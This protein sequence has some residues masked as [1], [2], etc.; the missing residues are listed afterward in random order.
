MK[1]S[2]KKN[3]I[4]RNIFII[5]AVLLFLSVAGGIAYAWF[6][7]GTDYIPLDTYRGSIRVAYFNG[8]GGTAPADGTTKDNYKETGTTYPSYANDLN[9]NSRT[10]PYQ[11]DN[12]TQ[13][14]NFAWLQYLGFFNKEGAD[15]TYFVL[16]NDIDMS[17]I[18]LPPIGNDTNP[19]IG[20]FDGNGNYLSASGTNAVTNVTSKSSATHWYFSNS[21]NSGYISTIIGTTTY[22]LRYNN[23]SLALTTNTNNRTSWSN[24][25]GG[26][27]Y[28]YYNYYIRFNGTTWITSTTNTDTPIS[29]IRLKDSEGHYV[30]GSTSGG[31]ATVGN[32]VKGS[33]WKKYNNYY[34]IVNDNGERSNYRLVYY[35]YS[36][37]YSEPVYVSTSTSSYYYPYQMDSDGRLYA[38]ISGT[39]YYVYYSNGSWA[40]TTTDVNAA[41]FTEETVNVTATS[42]L[43]I[44]QG[45]GAKLYYHSAVPVTAF[46]SINVSGITGTPVDLTNIGLTETTSRRFTVESSTEPVGETFFPLAMMKDDNG[47]YQVREEN[48][49]YIIIGGNDT[50]KGGDIR[51]SQYSKSDISNSVTSEAASGQLD[52]TKIYT[53]INS[54]NTN[55]SHAMTAAERAALHKFEDSFEKL[56]KTLE[57]T[58]DVYGLHFM[59][60]AISVSDYV[61]APYATIEGETYTNYE[62]PRNCIDFNLSEQG[63]IN[64]FAGSYFSGNNSFFSLHKIIRYKEGDSIPE[65]KKVNDLKEIR[66]I[67][68]VYQNSNDSDAPYAYKFSDGIYAYYTI[69]Q[70]DELIEHITSSLSGYTKIFDTSF[71]EQPN[72]LLSSN[73]VTKRVYYFEIPANKGEYALGSVSTKSGAYL[74]YLDIG[75]G[76]TENVP[77][78]DALLYADIRNEADFPAN[79]ESTT[80]SYQET[81]TETKSVNVNTYPTY[82]PLAF[83][84]Q[85]NGMSNVNTGYLVS[86]ATFTQGSPLGDIRVSQ[87]NKATGTYNI[88]ESLTNGVLTDSKIYTINGS[89][90]QTVSVYG[91]SNF[92]KY[93]RSKS[94]MQGVLDN[95]NYV[96]GL[97]FMDAR[98]G[99]ENLITVPTASIN[100]NEY[101]NYELP[102][103]CIDF[104]VQSRGYVNF[105]AG[106]F[107]D[108]YDNSFFSLHKI[109]RYVS[110]ENI[111]DGKKVGDIKEIKKISQ[112]YKNTANSNADYLYVYDGE[113]SVNTTRL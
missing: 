73:S 101:T 67:T 59:D 48:T 26:L 37:N 14:Y 99:T 28:N 15:Q 98:I 110:G 52:S 82:F 91:T 16:T 13:L 65:G 107:F 78:G 90:T 56:N 70:Y 64:F 76:G 57:N 71:I 23:G 44:D 31:N 12:A 111:P 63:Y 43:R 33:V 19:F 38:T 50:S 85:G 29:G 1:L 47:L 103:D 108:G 74:L 40:A 113:T 66:N 105:F 20:N 24:S 93:Q 46:E 83:N 49:G 102:R 34:Y 18:V 87:Y 72:G 39:K 86:G 53:T 81:V 55:S 92:Y 11:I 41:I 36:R 3:I 8:G 35:Y 45:E 95:E 80:I 109:I 6:S 22:Y 68:E 25:N 17:G 21:D 61:V 60:A 77:E 54:N 88:S 5:I 97:H 32:E 7:K 30:N 51:V 27:Y 89:G 69:D 104:N 42:T 10:G 2:E 79:R 94:Q 75:T 112:I 62:L 106:T 9:G 100:D 4:Y 58:T 96:Y 84:E